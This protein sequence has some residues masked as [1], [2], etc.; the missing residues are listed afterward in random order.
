ME[1]MR[2][3]VRSRMMLVAMLKRDAL[4]VSRILAG[5]MALRGP[6]D[7]AVITHTQRATEIEIAA[8]MDRRGSVIECL[9]QKIAR[10]D[11]IMKDIRRLL[12]RCHDRI[13]SL[14]RTSDTE[15]AASIEQLLGRIASEL[16]APR[17]G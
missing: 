8:E 1:D 16:G 10:S 4:S 11:S 14:P 5:L 15:L 9:E 6:S 3:R 7:M 13:H 12:V 17:N 2:G